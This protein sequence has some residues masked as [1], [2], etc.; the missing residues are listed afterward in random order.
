M[1]EIKKE[2]ELLKSWGFET[3]SIDKVLEMIE[4]VDDTEVESDEKSVINIFYPPYV[5]EEEEGVEKYFREIPVY[6]NTNRS[7]PLYQDVYCTG[8]HTSE[9]NI[10]IY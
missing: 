1:N 3:V 5:K 8:T 2:L 9:P 6:I 7:Y 10:W 4:R